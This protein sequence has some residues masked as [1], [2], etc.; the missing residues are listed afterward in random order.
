MSYHQKYL[1]YKKKYNDLKKYIGG[2]NISSSHCLLS[3]IFDLDC[4]LPIPEPYNLET[5][6]IFNKRLTKETIDFI[7]ESI[8]NY[9]RY[10]YNYMVYPQL[11]SDKLRNPKLLNNISISIIQ[12]PDKPNVGKI[13]LDL[14]AEKLKSIKILEYAKKELEIQQIKKDIIGLI[15][16]IIDLI[17]KNK[18]IYKVLEQIT[19]EDLNLLHE[20]TITDIIPSRIFINKLRQLVNS[21]YSLIPLNNNIVDIYNIIQDNR[22]KIIGIVN[23]LNSLITSSDILELIHISDNINNVSDDIEKIKLLMSNKKEQVIKDIL[24][25]FNK[26]PTLNVQILIVG[27]AFFD[28]KPNNMTRYDG[29]ANS[30]VIYRFKKNPSDT[31]DSYLC[32]RTEPHRH[33]NVYCRNSVRRAIRYIFATLPHSYYL[34]YIINTKTGLQVGEEIEIERENITDFNN[35]PLHIKKISPLQGNSGFCASWTIY[36]TFVLLLNRQVPLEKIGQYF[37]TFNQEFDLQIKTQKLLDAINSCPSIDKKCKHQIYD[38][39]KQYLSLRPNNGEFSYRIPQENY[40]NSNMIY[41]LLK[42]IKLYRIII[43]ILYFLTSVLKDTSLLDSIPNERDKQILREIFAIQDN[44]DLLKERLIR[45]STISL[46]FSSDILNR[47]THLCEDKIFKYDQLCLDKDVY[48]DITNEKMKL[49]EKNNC[50]TSKLREGNRIR[51]KGL[52]NSKKE[53]DLERDQLQLKSKTNAITL[54][55]EIINDRTYKV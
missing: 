46:Q 13:N 8:Q 43:Y 22:N 28:N 30:V 51:L 17:N 5:D 14:T 34:D 11:S 47:D 37:A 24:D 31:Y 41:I 23:I 39:V 44:R 33:T 52:V 9:Y 29:H 42:H 48:Y 38:D 32:L 49:L 20:L 50:L 10:F 19:D 21:N 53:K 7:R 45:S 6:Y 15:N 1:K 3:D 35:L 27:L 54:V 18:K 36:T 2:A 12:E 26:N 4:F 55:T 25:N 16:E 40:E